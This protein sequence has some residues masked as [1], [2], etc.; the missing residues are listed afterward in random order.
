MSQFGTLTFDRDGI[1]VSA[2]YEGLNSYEP[3]RPR[4]LTKLQ[5]LLLGIVSINGRRRCRLK[6]YGFAQCEW[7]WHP[8][9]TGVVSHP[10]MI[11]SLTRMRHRVSPLFTF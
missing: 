4:K 2:C 3:L 11:A 5:F 6:I 7:R 10:Q 8:V 1:I 9:H